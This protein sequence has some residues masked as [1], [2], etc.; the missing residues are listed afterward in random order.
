MKA[1][2][3]TLEM[4]GE[5]VAVVA[6]VRKS[7]DDVINVEGLGYSIC[8][9]RA[10][11]KF[12]VGRGVEIAVGRAKK[13]SVATVMERLTKILEHAVKKQDKDWKKKVECVIHQ[14]GL[15]R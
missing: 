11:D 4:A 5:L 1:I 13:L 6:K 10:G 14:L 7:G 8:N 12:N 15:I 2:I 9:N 3:E